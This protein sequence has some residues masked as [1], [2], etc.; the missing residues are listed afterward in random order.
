M[1]AHISASLAGAFTEN[2]PRF[3]L[4]VNTAGA[5][6]VFRNNKAIYVS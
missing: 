6:V 2:V 3:L 4:H 1:L 5:L